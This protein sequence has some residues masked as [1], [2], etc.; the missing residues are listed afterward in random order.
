MNLTRT[1]LIAILLLGAVLRL[2]GI[3]SQPPITDEVQVA[4]SAANYV[5]DG[6]FGPTM[7][8]HP[9]L[10]NIVVYLCIKIFGPGAMGLRGPSLLMGIASAAVLGLLVMRLTGSGLAAALAMFL[11]SI[12]PVHI[13]F[14]RQAI[15]EVHTA[16]FFLLGT[17]MFFMKYAPSP[18][19]ASSEGRGRVYMALSG[20]CFGLGLASKSHA[21]FPLL[22]CIA[23]AIYMGRKEKLPTHARVEDILWL[24]LLPF[25]VF[26]LTYIPWFQR[27]YGIAEWIYMQ[28]SLFGFMV[29]HAGNPMDS[30][31]DIR[32]ALWF[33]KPFMGYGSFTQYGGESYVTVAMGNPVIWL[34]VL[35]STVYLIAK[36]TRNRQ[37][38]FLLIGLFLVSYLPLA[39]SSRP[40]WLLSSIAVTPFAFAIVGLVLAQIEKPLAR[41]FLYAYLLL[42]FIISM[43]IYPMS[44]G[45]GWEYQHLRPFVERLNPHTQNL[46]KGP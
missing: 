2:Y 27:G 11:L 38:D 10:R 5:E 23:Y 33:I 1:L 41:R 15:Q 9:P 21:L 44:V 25:T 30:M 26:L 39:V 3:G 4:Y 35:P 32:P 42:A 34:S 18:N 28:R 7:P 45:K 13:T 17:L 31:I 46:I 37:G 12:D 43:L 40:I 19:K 29:S 8:Y 24:T 20:V 22:V 6:Q 14:S 36:G 16:F